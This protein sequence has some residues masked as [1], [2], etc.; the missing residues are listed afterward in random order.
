VNWTNEEGA[1][2]RPP[3]LASGVFA[4]VYDL[5]FALSR[6]DD[7]GHT[8]GSELTR[9][10]YAGAYD[11]GCPVA[12]YIEVHIE[13]GTVLQEA[14]AIIGNVTGV[15]GILDTKVTV[16][17]EDAHA[18]PLPMERRR[19]ALVG[20]AKMILAAQDVGLANA[21]DARVTIGRLSV[22]S[23][24]HSV[25]PGRVEMVLDIRHPQERAIEALQAALE[26]RFQAIA[27]ESGLKVAFEG[28]WYYQPVS[29][30]PQLRAAIDAGAQALGYAHLA[31]P[32]RA[33]HDAWNIARV[34]P[35]AMI[36]I[37]CRD[38][39]SHNEL[40]FAEDVHIAAGA[41]ILLAAVL[42]ADAAP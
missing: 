20:A 33:G 37:P 19:D 6:Q 39:I 42:A 7:A 30:A 34:A 5:E 24:S 21:P 25:V 11:A 1:R 35:A 3:L 8:V 16:T 15:V 23:N 41:D 27:A 18:G 9:I 31:L 26:Q 13:Q 22:P 4:G 32:S 36:F 40:E 38:G 2:F 17:G 10:G 14:R 12:G 29:F 28:L